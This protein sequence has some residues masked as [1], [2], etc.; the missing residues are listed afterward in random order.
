[1][2]TLHANSPAKRMKKNIQ[3]LLIG[4]FLMMSSVVIQAQQSDNV[5][6]K[7]QI[8]GTIRGKFEYQPDD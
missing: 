6:Y 1:M 7:P 4:F 2:I 5:D 8:D 3:T